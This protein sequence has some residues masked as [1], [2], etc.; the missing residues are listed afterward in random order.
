MTTDIR[1][2]LALIAAGIVGMTI[3]AGL[4]ALADLTGLAARIDR[5]VSAWRDAR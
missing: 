4:L 3:A 2:I 5:A 1:E